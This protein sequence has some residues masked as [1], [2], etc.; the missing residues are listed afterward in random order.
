[1][2]LA[3]VLGAQGE[4]LKARLK[5]IRDNLNVDSYNGIPKYI[6]TC[7]KRDMRYDRVIILSKMLSDVLTGDLYSY[8]S[9]YSPTTEIVFLCHKGSDEELAKNLANMFISAQV[10]EMLVEGVTLQFLHEAILLST[11]EITEKYGITDF[12]DVSEAEG[13]DVPAVQ[14]AAPAP[15]PQPEPQQPQQ[16]K[17]GL[18]GGLF[19]NKK[20]KQ[21][22]PQQ[23]EEPHESATQGASNPS[24]G[25]FQRQGQQ[26]D[27]VQLQ[28]VQMSSS[29]A[30]TIFPDEQNRNQRI[31]PQNDMQPENPRQAPPTRQNTPSAPQAQ[32]REMPPVHREN[33]VQTDVDDG[34]EPEVDLDF[35]PVFGDS[36][37]LS[38]NNEVSGVS[39]DFGEDAF[40]EE[41]PAAVQAQVGQEVDVTG[42]VL[43][44]YESQ[45]RQQDDQQRVVTKV[46]THEVVRHVGNNQSSALNGVFNG[47]LHKTLIV[48]GDRGS[49]VTVAAYS[50]AREFAK[51]TPV[52]YVD[53]DIERKGILSYID[54]ETFLA[55]D[56]SMREGIK[57][58][59]DAGV[60]R[61]CVVSYDMNIDILTADYSCACEDSDIV[62]VSEV[63]GEHIMDYGMVIFD[64]PISKLRYITDM[65]LTGNVAICMECSKRGVMNMLNC[66]EDLPIDVRYKRMMAGKGFLLVT[67]LNKRLKPEKVL[68]Y[69]AS[70]FESDGCDW[71]DMN[72]FDFD[73]RVTTDLM[74]LTVEG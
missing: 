61:N 5:N 65:I 19:G 62:K 6:D 42:D 34:F 54:Y 32:N 59:R 47:R 13:V 35:S 15:P 45:Y 40:S 39:L 30:D 24:E 2:K 73:G 17:K 64:C 44:G 68:G 52:L 8:W 74:T 29:T 57:R 21:G 49:G 51:K 27:S 11:R 12:L 50:L 36:D 33:P 1:M 48:T 70:I 69:A 4:K 20:K 31:L 56:P 16:K 37:V 46:V 3:L 23:S 55:Y 7:M 41:S 26:P 18:F 14:E 63:V 25:A 22:Q 60:F 28:P 9:Q 66:L 43:N 53:L 72:R 10:T 58:C 38:G 67:K 71:L